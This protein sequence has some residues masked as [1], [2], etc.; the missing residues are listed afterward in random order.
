MAM[1]NVQSGPAVTRECG[2]DRAELGVRPAL[3]V[4]IFDLTRKHAKHVTNLSPRPAA[5]EDL[6]APFEG[7]MVAW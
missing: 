7:S 6:A 1:S 3:G 5:S 2:M 4:S